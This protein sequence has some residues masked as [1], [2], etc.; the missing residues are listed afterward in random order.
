MEEEERQIKANSKKDK[1]N[2]L[3]LNVKKMMEESILLK[4]KIK[5]KLILD[6]YI[7]QIQNNI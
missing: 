6:G 1:D 5:P 7:F 2:R 4:S 3:P